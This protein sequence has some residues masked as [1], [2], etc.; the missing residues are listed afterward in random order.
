MAYK[1][2]IWPLKIPNPIDHA[3]FTVMCRPLGAHR[4]ET[5]QWAN[6]PKRT[7]YIFS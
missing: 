5:V 4:P 1:M 2:P 7:S 6:R 3:A